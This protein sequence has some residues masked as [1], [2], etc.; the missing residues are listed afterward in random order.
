LIDFNKGDKVRVISGDYRITAIGSEATVISDDGRGFTALDFYKLT[1]LP[2]GMIGWK[3]KEVIEEMEGGHIPWS[4]SIDPELNL[5]VDKIFTLP[6][7]HLKLISKC[8][9]YRR[10]VL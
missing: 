10:I 4:W 7:K 1:G 8:L 6:N 3:M 5:E 9:I 2:Q